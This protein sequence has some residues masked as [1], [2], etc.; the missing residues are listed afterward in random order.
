M[1]IPHEIQELF[2]KN[3]GK[4][5]CSAFKLT[6][7]LHHIHAL[8]F[9]WDGVFHSGHKS[10]NKA[11]S[12]S[13]A[14]SMGINMLRFAYFLQHGQIPF[15]AII[16][17]ENNPTAAYFAER[18]HL[19]A[20]YLGAKDKAIVLAALE[21]NDQI[22]PNKVWFAYDDILDLSVATQVG[23][24]VMVNRNAS[25]AFKQYATQHKYYDYFTAAEGHQHALREACELSL[26]LLGM[27]DKV[28]EERVAYSDLYATY[29][30]RRNAISSRFF[31]CKSG[32][33][34]L[35]KK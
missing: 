5:G 22:A 25:V 18:E 6:E 14:D 35:Q 17:G 26:S 8:V 3:G 29:I 21:Q 30:N 13:E 2:E 31:D 12:F 11:S 16:S 24:R 32:T 34:K 4:F 9:D 33:P 19:N 23:F 1:S 10:E 20:V 28:V 7:K 15:T 27:F